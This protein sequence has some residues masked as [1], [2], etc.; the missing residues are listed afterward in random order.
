MTSLYTILDHL[1]GEPVPDDW[2]EIKNP[3][4]GAVVG[5]IG[6]DLKEALQNHP[7]FTGEEFR[8]IVSGVRLS[9]E[10]VS[11]DPV[12]G[13]ITVRSGALPADSHCDIYYA[14]PPTKKHKQAQ[15]KRE[16][17]AFGRRK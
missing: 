2:T 14:K 1:R 4:T 7:A 10:D 17:A 9:P 5:W 6:D 16:T 12:A 3:Q 8:M 11:V 15:W 13:T